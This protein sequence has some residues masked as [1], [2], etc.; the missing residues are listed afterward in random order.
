MRDA[1]HLLTPADG[2]PYAY[3]GGELEVPQAVEVFKAAL[4]DVA[5]SVPGRMQM[6]QQTALA[7]LSRRHQ[8]LISRAGTGKSLYGDTVFSH[9]EGVTFKA[10][11][12]QGTRVETV[13]GGLDLKLFH[14][15]KLWHDTSHSLVTADFAYLDEFMNANDLVLEALLGILNERRFTQGEQQETAK[16]H[17]A[18]AMTNHL[19]Y[20]A[21]SEPILDRFM[22][23][24]SIDPHGDT[25]NDIRIDLAYA[26]HHGHPAP[27]EHPIPLHVLRELT[28]IVQGEHATR[29][30]EAGHDILFLKN[31]LIETFL[32][33]QDA[34]SRTQGPQPG[35][36]PA[37]SYVSPRTK[38][39]CR[40]VLNASA[41]L[42]HRGH[43]TKEDLYSLRYV[44]TTIPG[45][46]RAIPDTSQDT[47]AEAIHTTLASFTDGD[48]QTINELTTIAQTFSWFTHGTPLE[49][50]PAHGRIARIFLALIG[51][52]S[53]HEVGFDTFAEALR[54]RDISNPR[55]NELRDEMLEEILEHTEGV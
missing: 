4:L 15:G 49:S 39:A 27:P 22:F 20:S 14:E 54:S 19:K 9:F 32:R 40:D 5:D 44:L 17:T 16:L 46:D 31:E 12:T 51:K 26:R 28:D 47:F 25:L 34:H 1:H 55:V 37:D 3:K 45:N 8:L 43:V 11:F 18:L 48:L 52:G 35:G 29:E 13:L 38:A 36:H 2:R 30:I 10:Q 53:W 50:Q 7:L 21:I 23:K 33:L 42:H 41:L 6:L 24:A